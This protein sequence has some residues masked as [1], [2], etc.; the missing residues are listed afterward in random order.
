MPVKK[1]VPLNDLTM[2]V[3]ARGHRHTLLL[4]P[5]L[6]KEWKPPLKLKWESKPFSLGSKGA[7][8][9]KPGV[10]AFVIK[11]G[12]P[13]GVPISVL[14]YIGMS[15]RPLRE[16]FGEYLREMNNPS[17]RPAINTMLRMYV[18]YVHFYCACVAKPA[19]PKNIEGHLI[20]TLV[21]PMNKQYPAK[22]RR[23]IG[24]FS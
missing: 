11:P 9:N 7:I 1:Q 15:D 3:Y 10:Y 24:A 23:I 5:K 8:P 13:P 12:V 4:W 22:I 21:P 6:W 16:R 18:G 2:N 14:M 20:E 19:K 17:G